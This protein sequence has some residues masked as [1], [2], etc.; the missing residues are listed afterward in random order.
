MDTCAALKL[1]KGD[2]EL[3]SV[4]SSVIGLW[5]Y[6]SCDWV[7][8]PNQSSNFSNYL[9]KGK[10]KFIYGPKNNSKKGKLPMPDASRNEIEQ[11]SFYTSPRRKRA[12]LNNRQISPQPF[13]LPGPASSTPSSSVSRIFS[14]SSSASLVF[15]PPFLASSSSTPAAVHTP[16]HPKRRL[17]M[18]HLSGY[19]N[20]VQ[21]PPGSAHSCTQTE[22][23]PVLKHREFKSVGGAFIGTSDSIG[24]L[25]LDVQR[26]AKLC[27]GCLTLRS[28]CFTRKGLAL[29]VATKCSLGNLCTM[30]MQQN[31]N[32]LNRNKWD[33][34]GAWSWLSC[35]TINVKV[36]DKTKM[37]PTVNAK[38][39]FGLMMTQV[40][41]RAAECFL[42]A[43]QLTPPSRWTQRQFGEQYVKPYILR[44]KAAKEKDFISALQDKPAQSWSADVGHNHA[45]N[46]QGAT[47]ALAHDGKVL[48]TLT[49]TV[50]VPA[51]KEQW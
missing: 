51:K 32:S 39:T 47:L 28:Q 23:T 11:S 44:T 4:K 6:H 33:L 16:G 5:H 20:N 10:S 50:S 24:E 43:M 29:R 34:H 36:G 42:R 38:F 7:F 8:D 1:V 21:P 2:L 15:S 40:A 9:N 3:L 18:E 27:S 19:D 31:L 22:P 17:P 41:K 12:R 35:S 48:V 37:M 25:I 14:T 13:V 49:D 46:S 30:A 26:H 45:R